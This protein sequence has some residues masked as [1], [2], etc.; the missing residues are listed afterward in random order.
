[1]VRVPN[2]NSSCALYIQFIG[3]ECEYL[4][5]VWRNRVSTPT[6]VTRTFPSSDIQIFSYQINIISVWTGG[7]TAEHWQTKKNNL[8]DKCCHVRL[9]LSECKLMRLRLG[10]RFSNNLH[11]GCCAR[12]RRHSRYYSMESQWR[13]R[14]LLPWS[15]TLAK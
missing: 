2:S 14:K 6:S 8:R 9:L 15:R 4:L 3:M 7:E 11:S 1:M 12:I 13:E 5:F 10:T